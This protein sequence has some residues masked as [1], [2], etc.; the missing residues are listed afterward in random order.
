MRESKPRP[1][2]EVPRR[3]TAAVEF[4]LGH[5]RRASSHDPVHRRS[6]KTGCSRRHEKRRELVLE[7]RQHQKEV[8]D[9]SKR[10]PLLSAG[11]DVLVAFPYGFRADGCRVAA[12]V[13]FGESESTQ[14]FAAAQARGKARLQLGIA[15]S[16]N[17]EGNHIVDGQQ[18]SQ[19]R[20]AAADLFSEQ[21]IG[22]C[23]HAAS[24]RID[25]KRR[26]KIA[27]RSQLIDHIERNSLLTIP[28]ARVWRDPLL[29]K[30]PESQP[31]LFLSVR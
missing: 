19:R 2:N 29:N 11:D 12:C 30:F 9:L 3:Q 10:D 13:R 16:T 28:T 14:C 22:D 6:G 8:G 4:K 24:A 31:R 5:Q 20:T 17:G 27:V 18:R 25:R 26:S 7:S 1:A 21:S 15:P 23:V